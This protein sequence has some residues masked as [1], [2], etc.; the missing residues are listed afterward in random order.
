MEPKSIRER[1]LTKEEIRMTKTKVFSW[2]FLM[3][4]VFLASCTG[5]V[6]QPEVPKPG[7]LS[8]SGT[9][10]VYI[11][12]EI[13]R[14]NVGVRSR[15]DNVVQALADNNTNAALII[16]D[17]QEF[18]VDPADIQTT[19][20]NVY[21]EQ[22][23]SP[24]SDSMVTNYA[25]EN[26]VSIT[27]RDLSNFGQ[28][29]D[30]VVRRGANQIYGITYDVENQEQAISEARKLAIENARMRAEELALSAGV[31]LGK[32]VNVSTYSGTPPQ[33]FYEGKGPVGG[34]AQPVVVSGGQMVI[35]VEANLLYEI[36]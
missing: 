21:P 29:L 3:P 4:L 24:G 25:V 31:E 5:Q 7:Q 18:G 36:Q 1:L 33:P 19:S 10:T 2:I 34:Y 22:I 26:M 9:G 6:K 20:F 8:V 30:R 15:A 12:P 13:A 27:V 32:V 14:I 28:L 11:V 35:S 17:L 23:I 16:K